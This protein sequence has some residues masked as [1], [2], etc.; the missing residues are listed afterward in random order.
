MKKK[1][2]FISVSSRHSSHHA[3]HEAT[4]ESVRFN[5]QNY[6]RKVFAMEDEFEAILINGTQHYAIST[7]N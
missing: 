2:N 7:I 6:F 3:T 5:G 4:H 1:K